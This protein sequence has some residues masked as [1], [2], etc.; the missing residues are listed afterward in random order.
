MSKGAFG[1]KKPTYCA[2]AAILNSRNSNGET[3]ITK[4]GPKY[5]LQENISNMSKEMEYLVTQL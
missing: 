1:S 5:K 4:P 2:K 3:G